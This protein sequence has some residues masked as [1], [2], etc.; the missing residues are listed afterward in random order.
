MYGHKVGKWIGIF[1]T[2]G[3]QQANQGQQQPL[4]EQGHSL[5][6]PDQNQGITEW[7]S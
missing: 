2:M 6:I 1:K 5:H 7:L 3:R 4:P